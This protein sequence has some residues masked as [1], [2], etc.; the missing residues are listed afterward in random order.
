MGRRR[1][2]GCSR[3]GKRARRSP[4]T[5]LATSASR[6][7]WSRSCG[8]PP[9][10]PRAP[11][12][13]GRRRISLPPAVLRFPP[14]RAA[15]TTCPVS[16]EGG[17]RRVQLVREEGGRGGGGGRRFKV[18][19]SAPQAEGAA[20]A[21]GRDAAVVLSLR[22]GKGARPVST[23]GR[24][25]TCPLST[26]GRGGGGGGKR[27]RGREREKEGMGGEVHVAVPRGGRELAYSRDTG[28]G[29]SRGWRGGI[30]AEAGSFPR[31]SSAD[32]PPRVQAAVRALTA[33]VDPAAELLHAAAERLEGLVRGEGRGVST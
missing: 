20:R 32:A 12:A 1:R 7:R 24:D 18:P 25:E 29:N 14:A 33:D 3:A 22:E 16:T 21:A 2:C 6:V 13:E 26:G 11:S 19:A 28:R 30:R 10:S 23:G 8:A 4:S 27:E 9:G 5:S 15:P 31:G 17:T